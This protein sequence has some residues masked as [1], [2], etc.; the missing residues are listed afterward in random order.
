MVVL[1]VTA[2]WQTR[3]LKVGRVVLRHARLQKKIDGKT[4]EVSYR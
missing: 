3:Y 1:I 2:W 4:R